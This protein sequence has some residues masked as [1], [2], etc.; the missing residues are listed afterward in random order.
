[1]GEIRKEKQIVLTPLDIIEAPG[2]EVMHAMKASSPGFH[3]FG[4]AYFSVIDYGVIRAWKK[5]NR[6]T[7]NLVVPVGQVRFVFCEEPGPGSSSFKEIILSRENY[8]RITVPPGIWFG[9]QG[10]DARPSVLLN[11]AS[12]EHD[13]KEVERRQISEM[14]F[15]WSNQE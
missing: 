5:H 3:G 2:G 13:P 6:M 10:L 7:M 1:M 12:I 15:D 4:E 14:D 11:L 8:Q 9:F